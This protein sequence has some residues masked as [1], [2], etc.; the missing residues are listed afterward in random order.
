MCTGTVKLLVNHENY[1]KNTVGHIKFLA[2]FYK[3]PRIDVSNWWRSHELIVG[4][5]CLVKV[6]NWGQITDYYTWL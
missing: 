4:G 6:R 1:A 2:I 3:T 5:E